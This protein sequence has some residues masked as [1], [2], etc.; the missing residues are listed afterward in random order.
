VAQGTG[1][2][3]IL[4]AHPRSEDGICYGGKLCAGAQETGTKPGQG[5]RQQ[6][7]GVVILIRQVGS[8]Y[9]GV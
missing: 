5:G 2:L 6:F 1:V 7:C 8:R 3:Q 4:A 9:K